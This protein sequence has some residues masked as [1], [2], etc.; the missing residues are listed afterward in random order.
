MT[1]R[2]LLALLIVAGVIGW[3]VYVLDR[4]ESQEESGEIQSELAKQ[5]TFKES[6]GC[7][8]SEAVYKTTVESPHWECKEKNEDHRP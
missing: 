4:E 5:P 7:E 2:I 6:Y 1:G 3:A 8:Q